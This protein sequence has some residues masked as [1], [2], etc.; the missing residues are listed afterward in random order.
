[1]QKRSFLLKSA[2][3][4]ALVTFALAGCTTTTT[5][6]K[7]SNGS[8]RREVNEGI[9]STMSRL[10]TQVPGSRELVAKAN[11]V[12]VFPNVLAAGLGIGGE[13]GRG[14]LRVRGATTG[15]YSLGS[16]SVGLQIGAQSKAVV[17][18][19]MSQEALDKFRNSKGWTAGADASVAALKVGANGAVDTSSATGPVSAFVLTN[20][21]LMAN[22]NIE[23]T[24]I[25]RLDSL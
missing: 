19:F 13:Y 1:M 4:L 5:S 18:L 17:F 6:G 8:A 21:G 22:L 14:A 24:K 23:G 11:G 7:E 3:T 12:L 15:Y 10:Y 16:L 2:A 25:T 20:A 9:D